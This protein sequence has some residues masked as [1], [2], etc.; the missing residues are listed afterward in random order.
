MQAFAEKYGKYPMSQK[1]VAR[2]M[3]VGLLPGPGWSPSISGLGAFRSRMYT[4]ES[5]LN[6]TENLRATHSA[7]RRNAAVLAQKIR[8]AG[9][10]SRTR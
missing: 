1:I 7:P 8:S 2:K 9:R 4:L 3:G 6:A 5:I 10:L